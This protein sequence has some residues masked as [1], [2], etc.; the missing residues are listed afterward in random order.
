VTQNSKKALK[1]VAFAIIICAPLLVRAQGSPY[2]P[3]GFGLPLHS[4]NI[5]SE[6]LG[7]TGVAMGANR[8]INDLNPADWTWLDR[9]R[10]NV[11]LRFDYVNAQQ[12]TLQDVQHN[13]HFDGVSFGSPIWSPL[14]ASLALG[15]FPLTDASN[16]ISTS[17]PLGTQT[18]LTRGGTNLVFAGLAARLVPSIA[19]GVRADVVTGDIRHLAQVV[20]T[21]TGVDSSEFERDYFFYGVRPTFGIEFI[22]DSLASGLR[23]L[24]IGASY[25]LATNLTSTRETIITPLSSNLD[26]TIDEVGVGRYPASIAAGLSYRFSRRYRAEFDYFAQDFSSAFVYAPHSSSG[27]SLLRS[28]SRFAF[29][30]ERLPNMN[31]EYGTS[32]GFD[33]WGLR[34]GFSYGTLPVNPAGSGGVQELALSAGL[35]IPISYESLLN[36]SAVVGQHLP[37]NANSAPKETFVR[38]GADISFSERWFNPTRRD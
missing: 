14:N 16:E 23:G 11:A 10:F 34:L 2:G 5:T 6:A 15:Y 30:I 27:D 18:Y 9:A 35:G 1:V 8:T 31:G 24:T 4:S 28:S 22:G 38:L 29:G 37:Q 19:L 13:F 3:I 21:S 32:F 33:K 36:L 17:N 26:T 20:F 12:G 7:G 25:S